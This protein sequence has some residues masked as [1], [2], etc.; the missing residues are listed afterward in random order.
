MDGRH[1]RNRVLAQRDACVTQVRS[2]S[3]FSEQL[4]CRFW[5]RKWNNGAVC[6]GCGYARL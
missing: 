5:D 2:P 6:A 1:C 3:R 4:N